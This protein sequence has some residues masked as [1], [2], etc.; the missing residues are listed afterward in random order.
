ML[1]VILVVGAVLALLALTSRSKCGEQEPWPLDYYLRPDFTKT[2]SVFGFREVCR[3]V[4]NT[5]SLGFVAANAPADIVNSYRTQQ[6]R[7]ARLS[8]RITSAMLVRRLA[9]D[10]DFV[11]GFPLSC[12]ASMSKLKSAFLLGICTFGRA[13]L[14]VLQG[15]SVGIPQ[16]VQI[17]AS[18]TILANIRDLLNDMQHHRQATSNGLRDEGIRC[19]TSSSF[20]SD[21]SSQ[22]GVKEDILRALGLSLPNDLSRL[23]FLATLRDNNSGHYYHPEVARRFSIELADRAMLACHRLIYERVVALPLE[24]LTDQLDTYMATVPVAKNRILESWTKLRAYRATIPMNTDTLSA[25]VFF[26]KVGVAVAILQA[27]LPGRVQ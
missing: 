3:D 22:S 27:R 2:E 7:L 10:G 19:K 1:S 6:Q 5:K 8:L 24:D 23:I 26:M 25:E 4:S 14:R 15:L 11:D 18:A 17:L 9:H 12:R 20:F 13:G 16:R 21:E